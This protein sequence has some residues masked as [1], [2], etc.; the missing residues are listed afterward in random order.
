MFIKFALPTL[1]TLTITCVLT[2][3]I[4]AATYTWN[5]NLT[6][7]DT[8]TYDM[9]DD[10]NWS[11]VGVSSGDLQ[12]APGGGTVAGGP[13]TGD[14]IVVP[15]GVIARMNDA[16]STGMGLRRDFAGLTI[17]SN[18][19][20]ISQLIYSNSF[21][22]FNVEWR[23]RGNITGDPTNMG[24]NSWV[25]GGGRNSNIQTRQPTPTAP[26]VVTNFRSD[27]FAIEMFTN[28]ILMGSNDFGS[29]Q[30]RTTQDIH[31]SG[32]FE[33]RMEFRGVG[34]ASQVIADASI[35]VGSFRY[36]DGA[37]TQVLLGNFDHQIGNI[38]T[39]GA[40]FAA[41]SALIA[42]G[43]SITMETWDRNQFEDNVAFDLSQ[44]TINMFGNGEDTA[45]NLAI[46]GRDDGAVLTGYDNNFAL[47]T[48]VI[49]DEAG[50]IVTLL[51][52]GAYT[53]GSES[54]LTALYV[55]TLDLSSGA[56]LVVDSSMRLYYTN[57]I[58]DLSNV[59][60]AAFVIAIP[61]PGSLI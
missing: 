45:I 3:N 9:W 41:G 6:P 55:E 61:E 28:T 23:V 48:L 7:G 24:T 17:G 37:G 34:V 13:R 29:G 47:G 4:D 12:A 19:T 27:F 51:D 14:S 15:D 25:F 16:G 2:T 36:R 57:L 1:A 18:D 53:I 49:G 22:S 38:D 43:G 10:A 58:G 8:A 50:D 60:G 21:T 32:F 44:T 5:R 26:V 54:A 40:G 20:G 30:V 33:G 42:T 56:G 39:S 52:D 35:D 11:I 31:L 59:T 46:H